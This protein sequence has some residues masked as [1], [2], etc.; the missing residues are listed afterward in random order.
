MTT[1][2]SSAAGTGQHVLR[3][4]WGL[5]LRDARVL[6]REFIPFLL[7]TISVG[8]RGGRRYARSRE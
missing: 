1:V 2:T 7:R 3:A 8:R 5:M 4:F 6:A